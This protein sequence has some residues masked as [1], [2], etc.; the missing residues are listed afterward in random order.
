MT[1]PAPSTRP[2][3]YLNHDVSSSA[4]EALRREG[5]EVVAA[6]E[7]GMEKASDEE[8]LVRAAAEGRVLVSFNTR[9]Y[10]RLHAEFLKQGRAHAG[11]ALSKQLDVRNTI[12]ALRH[13]L[14]TTD[15]D[16][17]KNLVNWL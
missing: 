11:I 3:L 14:T 6:Q 4:A 2:R 10:P 15:A 9:D 13:I 17:W 12:R 5:Y 16:E 8:H 1:G 7:L